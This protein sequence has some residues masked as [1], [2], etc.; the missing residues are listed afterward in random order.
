MNGSR[1]CWLM[2]LSQPRAS[3]PSQCNR[4]HRTSPP[5]L[6]LRRLSEFLGRRPAAKD[7]PANEECDA[8]LTHISIRFSVSMS[9]FGSIRCFKG[10][11][12]VAVVF[13][14]FISGLGVSDL[15]AGPRVAPSSQ[16]VSQIVNRAPKSDRLPLAPAIRPSSVN[17]ASKTIAPRASASDLKLPNGCELLVSPLA[18]FEL[19][20]TAGRCV[21]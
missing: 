20:R 8:M 19:A 17:R 21:S 10:G 5:E 12:I 16:N 4:P 14:A 15:D 13:L 1:D 6:P 18:N 3:A 9:T 11:L 7:R 2:R